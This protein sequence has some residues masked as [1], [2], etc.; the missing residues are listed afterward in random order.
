MFHFRMMASGVVPSL[1]GYGIK[2]HDK[3]K[4]NARLIL[5]LLWRDF[6]PSRKLCHAMTGDSVGDKCIF[7]SACSLSV[8]VRPVWKKQLGGGLA[9]V[10]DVTW[11][12]TLIPDR[13]TRCLVNAREGDGD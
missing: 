13:S 11:T 2:Q 9:G 3:G 12:G 7:R 10:G 4:L 5:S 1:M 8:H 6:F